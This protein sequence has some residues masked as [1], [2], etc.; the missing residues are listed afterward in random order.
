MFKKKFLA[1]I[2][3][4]SFSA[5]IQ[6]QDKYFTKNAKIDFFSVAPLEDIEAKNKTGSA[7]LD[8][9]TGSLQFSVLMQGFEFDKALM[10]EHFNENYVESD[11]FP[12]AEFKGSIINNSEINYQKPGIY[13]AKVKGT[14]TLHGVTK[15]LQTTGTIKVN[16][17]N[18]KAESVFNLLLSDYNI[19]RPAIV[20]DKIS[21]TIKVTVDAKLDPLKN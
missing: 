1:L 12:K 10:Q 19:K 21:N 4:I 18:L 9:K 5:I 8:I 11:K 20:K 6:A 14:M 2:C 7:V 17:D 15:D 3:L 16:D 13:T